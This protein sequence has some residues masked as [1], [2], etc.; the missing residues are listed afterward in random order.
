[1]LFFFFFYGSANV[2]PM[3]RIKAMNNTIHIGIFCGN[4][5]PTNW[6]MGMSPISR[7][8]RNIVS[9]TM[10][11]MRPPKMPVKFSIPVRKKESYNIKV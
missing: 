2:T 9:P 8:S 11:R 6:P 5:L 4:K 3:P 1:M 7:P 10:T